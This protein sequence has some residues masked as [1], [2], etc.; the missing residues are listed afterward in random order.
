MP[1]NVVRPL[2]FASY[3]RSHSTAVLTDER[4]KQILKS[5]A[6]MRFAPGLKTVQP[7]PQM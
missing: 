3:I 6:E 5:I 4:V 2:G 7:T 1:R